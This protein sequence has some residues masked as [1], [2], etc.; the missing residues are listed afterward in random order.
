M[1][2]RRVAGALA[3][4][5][6]ACASADVSAPRGA[7]PSAPPRRW[8]VVAPHPDDEALIA[9][10]VL[11]RASE[12]GAPAFVVVMT[13]GDF[14][15]QH[16]GL[17]RERESL[18]G[19]AA[20][21]VAPS[22]VRFLGYPD[23]GLGALGRA[24]LARRRLE[25]GACVL[26][27]T[28]YGRD[29]TRALYTRANAVADVAA[30]LAALRPTDVAVTHPMD[31][32][33]DHAATY[34]LLRDAMERVADAPRVH[35][36][37]VHAGDCWPTGAEPREPC[38]PATIAPDRP[39]PPL[40]NALAGYAA[41][42]RIAVP[43]SCRSAD[44]AANPKLRAIAAHRSQTRGTLAS[45]L[46][47]FARSDEAFFPEAFERRA[48]SWR[49]KDGSPPIATRTA[50]IAR[51]VAR[52]ALLEDAAAGYGVAID[53]ARLEARALR[54]SGGAETVLATWPLPHDLWAEDAEEPF[55]ATVDPVPGDGPVVEISLRCRGALVGVAAS[56]SAS[57]SARRAP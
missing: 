9:G 47:A 21:G 39:T 37:I 17:A 12:D 43:A 19:L 31:T 14:D 2:G 33:P 24:P 27:D 30:V 45:Y 46:F 5:L 34:A 10:G 44:P 15:C 36:A 49:R 20:L 41:R 42:E 32:H 56:V 22:R 3:L 29:A 52:L 54:V 35:R 1:T 57:P 48:G 13:N 53:G 18:A 50:R 7:T 55:E 11:A 23:G 25:A 51:G 8:L 16:D 40:A 28:T 4:T 38:P 6:T 26:G